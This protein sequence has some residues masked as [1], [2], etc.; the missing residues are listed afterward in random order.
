[1]DSAEVAQARA[2]LGCEAVC[3]L[4]EEAAVWASH[5]P[6]EYSIRLPLVSVLLSVT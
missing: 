4:S 5:F 6:G 1:M 3:T 2:Q